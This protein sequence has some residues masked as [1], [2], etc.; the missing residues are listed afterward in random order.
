MLAPDMASSMAVSVGNGTVTRAVPGVRSVSMAEIPVPESFFGRS[1]AS[2]DIRK[3]YG[4]T[5]LL[6]KR[7]SGGDEQI[8]DQLP[9]AEYVFQ[10][11]DVM[12]VMG[13]EERLNRLERS[14]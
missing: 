12:L 5:V 11:G 10:E 13:S 1:L 8:A 4:V 14:G 7:R 2:M 9:D 3:R 6:I